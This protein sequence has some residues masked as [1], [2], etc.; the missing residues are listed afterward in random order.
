MLRMGLETEPHSTRC[1]SG[2]EESHFA[3][4][5]APQLGSAILTRCVLHHLSY[6]YLQVLIRHTYGI[7]YGR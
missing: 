7:A 1:D 3:Q 6:R 2:A 4:D 5:Y